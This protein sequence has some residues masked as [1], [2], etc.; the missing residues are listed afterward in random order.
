MKNLPRIGFGV[1]WL[2]RR[3]YVSPTAVSKSTDS[4]VHWL[5]KI[6]PAAYSAT[7]FPERHPTRSLS[8]GAELG[9]VKRPTIARSFG[10]AQKACSTQQHRRFALPGADGQLGNSRSFSVISIQ[11]PD[12]L[13]LPRTQTLPGDTLVPRLP[14]GNAMLPRL[15]P[16]HT[17]GRACHAP[18]SHA[19]PENQHRSRKAFSGDAEEGRRPQYQCV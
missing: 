17:A 10:K 5:S 11:L 15:P 1:V 2:I 3:K 12:S 9:F 14:H 8:R 7:A 16:R 6:A 18:G 13:S 4:N 19:E